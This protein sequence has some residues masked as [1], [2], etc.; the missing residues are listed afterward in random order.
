M[1]IITKELVRN[2]EALREAGYTNKEIADQMGISY[3]SVLKNIGLQGNLRGSYA[4]P[5]IARPEPR[6]DP[7]CN[8]QMTRRV[9][10]M[11]GTV[12]E[13]VMDTLDDTCVIKAKDPSVPFEAM[14]KRELLAFIATDFAEAAKF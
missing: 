11:Q 12:L 7:K 10:T 2:M 5:P 14:I 13:F 1:A 4:S 6:E 3:G 9:V 8:L